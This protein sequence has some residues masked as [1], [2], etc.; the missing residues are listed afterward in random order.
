[1]ADSATRR[2]IV[3]YI[4]NRMVVTPRTF[5]TYDAD[6]EIPFCLRES[7]KSFPSGFNTFTHITPPMAI[8]TIIPAHTKD[9]TTLSPL[10]LMYSVVKYTLLSKAYDIYSLFSSTSAFSI[11]GMLLKYSRITSST[12]YIPICADPTSEAAASIIS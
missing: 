5:E 8:I 9:C 2:Y 7:A 4:A 3:P 6:V 10:S 12:E 1:M 11:M